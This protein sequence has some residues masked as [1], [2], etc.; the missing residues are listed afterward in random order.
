MELCKRLH[1]P[2][3]FYFIVTRANMIIQSHDIYLTY[4]IKFVVSSEYLIT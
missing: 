2:I 4:I 1:L 3:A